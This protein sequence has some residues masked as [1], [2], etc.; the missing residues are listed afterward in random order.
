[1]DIAEVLKKVKRPETVV[2]I[3]LDED[4]RSQWE[5]LQ[6]QLTQLHRE[7]TVDKQDQRRRDLAQRIRD[8]EADMQAATVQFRLRGLSRFERQEW[9]DAYPARE[10]KEEAFD[11]AG[12]PALVAGCCVD[13]Q[14][15]VEQAKELAGTLGGAFDRL[16]VAAWRVSTQD[17]SVPFSFAASAILQ[18]PAKK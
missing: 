15:T 17:G 7:A 13:P 12:E 8:V 14:M 2:P 5:Q 1:V 16:S 4:L 10:G 18:A 9:M 6:E 11:P 3:C